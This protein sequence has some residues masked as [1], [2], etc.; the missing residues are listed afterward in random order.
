M[1]PIRAAVA[2]LFLSLSLGAAA[3]EQ[4]K[5][6]GNP[7]E[8]QA[9][10]VAGPATA[11]KPPPGAPNRDAKA[12][13]TP[14]ASSPSLGRGQ[15]EGR[16]STLSPALPQGGGRLPPGVTRVTSVEGITEY[17]LPNGLQVLLFPDASKP[18]ITVNITYMVG[19]RHENYGETGMAH[20]L[21]HLLFKG[22]PKH[23][24]IDQEFNQRGARFNGTTWLDRTNYYELVQAGDDNLEWAIELEADRMVNSNIAK[25]DLDSEMT[26]VRNEYESGENSPFSVL[27]KRMQSITF[28]WHSY[29][30]STIGNK[31]DIENVRIENLKAFY[32]TYYQPDNA[33][34]L[35]AGKFEESKALALVAKHFAKVKKPTRKLPPEWTQEPSQD[36]NRE[37]TVRRKGDI[38]IVAIAYKVP[39]SLHA[40]SD[41]LAF[42]NA[43]L[44]QAPTGRLHKE[45]VEKGNKASQV[46]GFPLMG[47]HPGIQIFGAVLKKDDK[48]EP[49]RDE[50]VK[51][52]ESFH[53]TPPTKEEMERTRQASL[54]AA[55]KTLA[56]HEAIGVQM[57]EYIAMGDWR[58][59]F[60]ARD[61][62]AKV[63]PEMV[64]AA[65]K[66]YFRR[67]NRTVGIFIPEDNPLRAELPAT[68]TVAE[69]MKDFKAKADTS[70]SEAFDPSQANIDKRTQIVTFGN[71]KAALLPKKNRGEIVN[72]AIGMRIG[73]EKALFGQ[74]N[75]SGFAG[76][77]L[78]RGTSKYTRSQLSDEFERLKVSGRVSGPGANIQTT[79]ANLEEALRL[80]AHVLRE[81]AFPEG[82]FE[83]LR[84]QSITGIMS[85]LSEPEA[86]AGEAMSKH[87]N[88]YPKGDWRYAPTLEEGLEE[89]KAAKLEDAKRFHAQFYGA[90]PA[91][92]AI[93]GDFDAASVTPLL[94]ELFGDWKPKVPYERVSQEYREVAPK[95]FSVATPD[96]E[97]A[98]FIARQNVNMRD[99]DPDFPA[100]YVANYI[101]G[102]GAGFDSRLTARIRQKDGL[103]YGVGSDLAVGSQDRAGNWSAYAIA[104]PANIAKVESA[105]NEELVRA[106]KDGFTEAEVAAAKSGIIQTR[107]QTR[108]QDGA[109]AGGWIANLHLGRTYTFSKQLED[110]IL[111]LKVSDVNAALRKHVDPSKVTIVKAGDFSK[112]K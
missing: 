45:I 71:V 3:Q 96:K 86:R 110:K 10:P 35:I 63:T 73:N 91:Q 11:P 21:E 104:A 5:P 17:R 82:E 43:I 111:A 9:A 47:T 27:L 44:S 54:N 8:G 42:A 69:V 28:D 15:R 50:I 97:N 80:V 102:G 76:A 16:A 1:T 18:T 78:S 89:A 67:D 60:L 81:P 61:D 12:P 52:I 68:P 26:V 62:I 101:L 55:E 34:L 33:T 58:L 7:A 105:F 92:I 87:F 99:D 107:V 64:A 48:V 20:L 2:G 40:D 56:N 30:R 57:S 53:E 39:S 31:S 85:Q 49:V 72:V 19:S 77:M 23:P 37:F 109:L 79:R 13:P 103:S 22:T 66:A 4:K 112:V 98:V 32:K 90:D 88:I 100:L 75:I 95:N 6:P 84:N 108:S 59:F 46:F 106:I 51:I 38:Q 36:G 29:G 94:K 83:Q 65:S 74:Q 93:V 41:G 25:K 70:V 24:A 14:D